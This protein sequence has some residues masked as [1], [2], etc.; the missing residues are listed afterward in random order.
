MKVG[1]REQLRLSLHNPLFSAYSLAFRAMAVAAAIVKI[2]LV[3]ARS[4]ATHVST[5]R[6]RSAPSNSVQGFH[7]LKT[8][9]VFGEKIFTVKVDYFRKFM[10]RL[11]LSLSLW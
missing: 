3:S 4:A 5:Q 9:W 11:H 7:N 8:L 6:G 10:P 2:P 1:Y